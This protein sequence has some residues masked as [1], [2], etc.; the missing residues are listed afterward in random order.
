ME[1]IKIGTGAWDIDAEKYFGNP[2]E[3]S[4]SIRNDIICETVRGF[5]FISRTVETQKLC[6][7]VS[8]KP[9]ISQRVDKILE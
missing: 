1:F 8:V 2:L 4:N 3:I 5:K 6:V 9:N 7:C